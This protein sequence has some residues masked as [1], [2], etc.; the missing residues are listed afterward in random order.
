MSLAQAV[1]TFFVTQTRCFVFFAT[2]YHELTEISAQV[3]PAILNAHMSIQEH[4]G[5]LVFLRKLVKGTANKSYGLEVARLAGMP[6][7]VIS[8]ARDIL[9]KKSKISSASEVKYSAQLD[10]LESW[11]G[12]ESVNEEEILPPDPL[13][14]KLQVLDLNN[15]TPLQALQLLS[16]LKAEVSNAIQN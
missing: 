16:E 8:N 7:S 10:L 15:T 11:N 1:L 5:G 9:S 4:K 14:E 2:H 3:G 6:P 12:A 13:R